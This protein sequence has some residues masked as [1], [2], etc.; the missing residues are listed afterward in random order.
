[1]KW[2]RSFALILTVVAAL[3][4]VKAGEARRH[5]SR[6]EPGRFDY[7]LL[8]LSVAPSFCMLSASH[9]SSRECRSLTPDAFRQTPLT[10]HGLWPNRA[11]VSV[12]QQP[13]DCPGPPFRV[14]PTL[15]TQL[16]RY[17]PGGSGLAEYEWRKHGTCSGLASEVYFSTIV[18]LAQHANDVIG[19]A[20]RSGNMLGGTLRVPD[21]LSAVAVRDQPLAAAIVV[22]CRTPRGGGDALVEEIRL[23]LSKDFTPKPTSQVG[24]GQNSGCP[25]GGGRVPDPTPSR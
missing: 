15:E 1:M 17:M 25:R 10:V 11:E 12:N 16:A 24:L 8:S 19:S 2:V 5:H 7:Y 9:Q 3:M 18:R 23:I 21:L 14:S 20:M 6:S 4:G 13:H 22:D